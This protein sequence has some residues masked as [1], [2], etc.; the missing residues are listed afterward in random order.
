MIP[1]HGLKTK[2]ELDLLIV[3]DASLRNEVANL[4]YLHKRPVF[5]QACAVTIYKYHGTVYLLRVLEP[6]PKT[7]G[8]SCLISNI[9]MHKKGPKKCVFFLNQP[10]AII[11][12]VFKLPFCLPDRYD[13][14]PYHR[15]RQV[16]QHI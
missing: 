11:K 1:L 8:K 15:T 13:Q 3:I 5:P 7:M 4:K 10:L 6:E 2:F 9:Y 12:P 16:S 14:Q